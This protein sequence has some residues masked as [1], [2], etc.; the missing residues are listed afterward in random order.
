M[1]LDLI[2]Y[3]IVGVVQ[4]FLLTANWMFVAKEKVFL[5]SLFSFLTTVMTI[6]VLYNILTNLDTQRSIVAIIV[7]A[8]GI[9]TGTFL[10]MKLKIG[11]KE[12]KK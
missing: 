5:A 11:T 9:A 1:F 3:F 7:Y 10:A 4:D 6:L 12:S 8:L 2:I